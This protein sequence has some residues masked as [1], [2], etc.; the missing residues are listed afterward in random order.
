MTYC[1]IERTRDGAFRLKTFSDLCE[2]ETQ[3]AILLHRHPG[4]DLD[5]IGSKPDLPTNHFPCDPPCDLYRDATG[6]CPCAVRMQ[7]GA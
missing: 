1:L 7:L 6:R 4:I 5:I 2:A 3:M